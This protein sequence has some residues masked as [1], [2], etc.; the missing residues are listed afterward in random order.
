MG[1]SVDPE[2]WGWC[3]RKGQLE[4]KTM[5]SPV[6]PDTLNAVVANGMTLNVPVHVVNAKDS[7]RIA[8]LMRALMIRVN[9]NSC[10][11]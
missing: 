8:T 1:N 11:E 3:L 7:V 6:A 2:K 9:T 10:H 5:D 4:P